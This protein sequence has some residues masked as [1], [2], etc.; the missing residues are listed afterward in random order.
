MQDVT[1]KYQP[2]RLY[3]LPRLEN[4]TPQLADDVI[5]ASFGSMPPTQRL[6]TNLPYRVTLS[7]RLKGLEHDMLMEFWKDNAYLYVQL[8]MVIEDSEERWYDCVFADAPTVT[9]LGGLRAPVTP[10]EVLNGDADTEHAVYE[11]TWTVVARAAQRAQL[12]EDVVYAFERD[13]NGDFRGHQA[14]GEYY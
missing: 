11:S 5:T 4:F 13:F 8:K 7:F 6:N 14:S 10:E 2:E 12:D 9:T 3:L 1:E